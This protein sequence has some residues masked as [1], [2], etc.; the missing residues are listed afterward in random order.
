MLTVLYHADCVV[1]VGMVAKAWQRLKEDTAWMWPLI[2]F[3]LGSASF[4]VWWAALRHW[5]PQMCS[6]RKQ[7]WRTL[8]SV[9]IHTLYTSYVVKSHTVFMHCKSL[10]LALY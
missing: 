6:S 10:Y 7:F 9:C 8:R 5:L 1:R 4:T 3:L 2:K